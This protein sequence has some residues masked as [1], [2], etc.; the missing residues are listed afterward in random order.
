VSLGQVTTI[1]IQ[2]LYGLGGEA[3]QLNQSPVVP[4][5]QEQAVFGVE[6]E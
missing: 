6:I 4:G 1:I 5:S 3:I 2:A